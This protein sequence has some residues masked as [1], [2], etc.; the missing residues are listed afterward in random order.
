[1][2]DT[3]FED[4]LVRVNS[5]ER[6]HQVSPKDIDFKI[7]I[8]SDGSVKPLGLLYTLKE[9]QV[10]P[11]EPD[12][13]GTSLALTVNYYFLIFTLLMCLSF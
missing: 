1:M 5:L 8:Y 3:E 12:L 4:A 6:E 10:L 13:S 9:G 2:S 11:Y 7:L